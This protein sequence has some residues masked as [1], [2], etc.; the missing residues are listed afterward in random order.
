M[1]IKSIIYKIP[2]LKRLAK[3]TY[4]K[5]K[6][7]FFVKAS[8][9]AETDRKLVVFDAYQGRSFA[10]SPKAIYE[11]MISEP[12][13]SDYRFVWIFRDTEAH[14]TFPENTSLLKFD[15][16]EAL[17]AYARAGTW[18]TNSRLRDF[19][20]PR[21][22]Q[23]YVQCWHGTP[24]KKIGCDI[25]AGGNATSSLNEIHEEYLSEAKRITKMISPS[26]FC[27]SKL[28]SAFGLDKLSKENIIIQKGYPRNDA[29]FKSDDKKVMQIKKSLGISD[30]KKIILYCPTFRDN[31]HSADGYSLELKLDF[32]KLRQSLGEDTVILFRAHYFIAD[33]FD[34]DRYKGYVIN[35]SDYDDINDLYIISDILVTDYSS[36]FFDYANLRRPIIF[37][38]YDI[39][40]YKTKMRDFYFGTAM[41][42]GPVAQTQEKLC[43]LISTALSDMKNGGNGLMRYSR[44]MEAFNKRFN[45]LDGKDCARMVTEEIFR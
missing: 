35:V 34:F 13:F 4:L 18:I 41:L 32:E 2:P 30:E 29:L 5:K 23:E 19:I 3:K 33:R 26:D 40:D 37:Y 8:R 20:V 24:F 15:S 14:G 12:K 17:D 27:T 10:C 42:P 16:D 22:D 11:Y 45:S 1:N 21:K 36:V 43:E 6:E 31:Q 25:E 28:I 38:Q 44:A 39:T 9:A 7:K